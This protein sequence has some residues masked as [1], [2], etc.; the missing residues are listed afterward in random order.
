MEIVIV[1]VYVE[2]DNHIE[3]R[4]L[5]EAWMRTARDARKLHITTYAVE[6][7]E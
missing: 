4:G 5:V 1:R 2:S 7:G 6:E 3:A